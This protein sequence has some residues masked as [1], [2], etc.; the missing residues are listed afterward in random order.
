MGL[1]VESKVKVEKPHFVFS[2][3]FVSSMSV[4][5]AAAAAPSIHPKT[6]QYN[7]M[8]L[9][10]SQFVTYSLSLRCIFVSNANIATCLIIFTTHHCSS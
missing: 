9:V 6:T 3:L 1:I 7:T 2:G 4:I 10:L 5:P 8:S